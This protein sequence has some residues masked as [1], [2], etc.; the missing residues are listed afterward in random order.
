M[1]KKR[2]SRVTRNAHLIFLDKVLPE[3]RSYLDHPNLGY[4]DKVATLTALFR[5]AGSW[6]PVGDAMRQIQGTDAKVVSA[7]H[8]A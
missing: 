3:L 8:D 1:S 2:N 5:L 6:A 4:Y 7:R